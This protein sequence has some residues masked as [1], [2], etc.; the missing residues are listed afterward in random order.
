MTI[1]LIAV[2]GLF[3]YDNRDYESTLRINFTDGAHGLFWD[4]FYRKDPWDPNRTAPLLYQRI[5]QDPILNATYVSYFECALQSWLSSLA[6]I[7]LISAT[8]S[9]GM[10][11]LRF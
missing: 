10:Q 2:T 9:L 5:V 7:R 1:P 6:L 8:L 11:R 4:D 3:E